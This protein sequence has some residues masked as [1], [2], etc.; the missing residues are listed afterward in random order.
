MN[1]FD[2]FKK[3]VDIFEAERISYA[4]AGGVAL[5]FYTEP[6]FTRDIDFLIFST[7][8]KKISGILEKNGYFESALPWTFTGIELTLH[9]FM[10][11]LENEDEMLIDLLVGSSQHIKN[12]L[13]RA[14]IARSGDGA[15]RVVKKEDLIY[16]KQIR[17][18]SQDRLDIEKLENAQNR[19]DTETTE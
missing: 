1:V 15:V 7:D 16:L 19:P 10:K 5:S 3:I 8:L 18:S 6:R 13:R 11:A 12:I 14:M 9:R 17:N 4:L 2:E